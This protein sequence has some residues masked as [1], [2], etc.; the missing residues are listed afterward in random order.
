M[1]CNSDSCDSAIVGPSERPSRP[2][3]MYAFYFLYG[4]LPLFTRV[5]GSRILRSRTSALRSS[6]KFVILRALFSI[7]SRSDR[8]WSPVVPRLALSEPNK[9]V[10]RVT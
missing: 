8:G 5:G 10:K 4:P 3:V 2:F 1:F 6:P 9:T 7:S